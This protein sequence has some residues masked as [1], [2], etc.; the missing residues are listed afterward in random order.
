MSGDTTAVFVHESRF[1]LRI[2]KHLVEAGP[3]GVGTQVKRL[4]ALFRYES[5]AQ[6]RSSEASTSYRDTPPVG[7]TGSGNAT[8][9]SGSVDRGKGK[10]KVNFA[11]TPSE[12]E[13]AV[14]HDQ[15][16]TRA[17][18]TDERDASKSEILTFESPIDGLVTEWCA[19]EGEFLQDP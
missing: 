7:S 14:A 2:L 8:A 11:S 12:T 9:T 17:S 4:D 16:Y 1:P 15:S 5:N 18:G 10:S 6:D 19:S 13:R 3:A